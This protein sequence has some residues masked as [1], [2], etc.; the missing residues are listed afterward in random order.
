MASF[1]ALGALQ[2]GT[3]VS[4]MLFGV[5]T[6]QTY[7]YFTRFP[8]DSRILKYLV[9]FVYACEIAHTLCIA[10]TL[11]VY[12][13]VDYGKPLGHLKTD[14]IPKSL[15]AN[16]FFTGVIAACVQSFFAWRIYT[17]SNNLIIPVFCWL[18]AAFRVA[19]GLLS[20][21]LGALNVAIA[22]INTT[23]H[24]IHPTVWGVS[25][26]N[27]VTLA[28]ALIY[29]LYKQRPDRA[30]FHLYANDVSLAHHRYP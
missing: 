9:T 22:G 3:L 20:L 10:H 1:A 23:W 8:K 24:W 18:L 19:I 6:T 28:M 4:C 17:L 15:G 7:I 21:I 30:R 25:A 26:A 12:T 27:N 2:I 5:A 13:I 29:W 11:Y 16:T 14:P